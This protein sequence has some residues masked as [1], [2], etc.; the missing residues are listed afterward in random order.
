MTGEPTHS[1]S[2]MAPRPSAISIIA[3]KVKYPLY[4]VV[5]YVQPITQQ[6]ELRTVKAPLQSKQPP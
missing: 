5:S 4:F 2:E 3:S 1:A 6:Y